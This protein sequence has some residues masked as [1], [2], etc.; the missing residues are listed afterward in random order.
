[1]EDRS[2]EELLRHARSLRRLA[3]ALVGRQD[4]DDLVQEA[5][6]ATLQQPPAIADSWFPWLSGVLRFVAGKRRRSEQ[7]RVR[8]EHAVAE[9]AG[10]GAAPAPFDLAVQRATIAELHERLLAVPEPYHGTL[11]LRYF[12]ELSPQQIAERTAVPLA[13]VKS[14]LQRG[15]SLLRERYDGDADRRGDWRAGL[16]A[17]FG[18]QGKGT[19]V[20]AT[21]AGAGIVMGIK[22][23]SSLVAVLVAAV[24]LAFALRPS[25]PEAA[26]TDAAPAP[27]PAIAAAPDAEVLGRRAADAVPA[28][29]SPT[30]SEAADAPRRVRANGR[31]VDEAHQPLA[32]VAIEVA[33]AAPPRNRRQTVQELRSAADGAFAFEIDVPPQGTVFLAFRAAGRVGRSG[34]W[35][36]S[37][38][39]GAVRDLG[40]VV[41]ARGV[42]VHG[43]VVDRNGVPQAGVRVEASRLRAEMGALQSELDWSAQTSDGEGR[44]AFDGVFPLGPFAV[45]CT[46]RQLLPPTPAQ[47]ELSA[48]SDR[49][50]CELVVAPPPVPCRGL[51]VDAAGQPIPNAHVSMDEQ[52]A[53]TDASGRFVVEQDPRRRSAAVEVTADASDYEPAKTTWTRG[54]PGELRLVLLRSPSL[55]LHVVDGRSGSPLERFAVLAV[56]G[57]SWHGMQKD[58]PIRSWPGGVASLP[59]AGGEWHVL[60]QPEDPRLAPSPWQAVT[61]GEAPVG[62]VRVVLQPWCERR[63]VVTDGQRALAG[64]A[65]ELLDALGQPLRRETVTT[66]LELCNFSIPFMAFVLQAATTD[67]D[68]AVLLRGPVGDL[69]LRLCGGGCPLHLVDRVRLDGEG[70]LR[71]QVPRGA[72]WR[73]RLVPAEVVRDLLAPSPAAGA[74]PVGL[75]LWDEHGSL[76]RFT[77]APFPFAADGSFE[78]RDLPPGRWHLTVRAFA[79]FEAAVV[80]LAA[81]QELQQDVDVQALAVAD[82]DLYVRLDGQLLRDG[83]INAIGTQTLGGRRPLLTQSYGPIG[84]GGR[85]PVRTTVG[86]LAVTIDPVGGSRVVA[87]A[88]VTRPGPQRMDLELQLGALHATVQAP[89]GAM[90]ARL[91]CQL[92]AGNA[93]LDA[94]TDEHG[95]LQHPRAIAGRYEV[96][97]RPAALREHAAQRAFQAQF[98]EDALSA[99]W[100]PV[101]TVDVLPGSAAAAPTSIRLPESWAT[102]RR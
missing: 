16:A 97:V 67:A 45:H 22:G 53:R 31:C 24:T 29:A 63:L 89:D 26:T 80:E 92:A 10:L 99:A 56:H 27:V 49:H 11:L 46:N 95:V 101:G 93:R 36:V 1:M 39:D 25:L 43:R 28:A 3:V 34:G 33:V 15:L 9:A 8:R 76:R 32:D 102:W 47:W 41:L 20:A 13:T 54:D 100:L 91:E 98:G 58:A 5:M 87:V 88:A 61:L 60:V 77:E 68:G 4:A 62:V 37:G 18:L 14:R 40:H 85:F 90:V 50:L 6:V 82:V 81:G 23:W 71:L 59:A 55:Q 94:W 2:H 51:V 7:R 35:S 70:E 12:Q 78:L 48:A 74:R 21:A 73:G 44:F 57:G 83:T 19:T 30:A 42:A 38:R 64:V 66:P 52:G 84:E 65:V 17:A 72:V 75:E 96:R 86:E 69:G 79:N